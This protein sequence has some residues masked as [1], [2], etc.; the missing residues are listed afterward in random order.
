MPIETFVIQHDAALR[1]GS[2]LIALISLAAWELLVPLR[3]RKL[4]TSVRW[5]HTAGL[6]VLN[7]VLMR[8]L[9]PTA[10]VAVAAAVDH[11]RTGLLHAWPVPYALAV[12]TALLAFDFA[13]YLVHLTFHTAPLLWRIHRLHHADAD[14]DVFTALRFHPIQAA[15]STLVKLGV[16]VLL[17]APV[18]AVVIFETLFHALLLFNHANVR[19]RPDVDRVLRWF[20]V[21]P[22]MHCVHHSAR[23]QETNS[24]FGFALPWWD[25]LLGTYRAAPE[26]GLERVTLGIGSFDSVQDCRLDRMLLNPAFEQDM[27]FSVGDC[28]ETT[29]DP[30]GQA[31]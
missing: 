31:R 4:P 3:Q 10:A 26:E 30:V 22:N 1:L 9:F 2:F 6:A 29:P 12:V 11:H 16:I 7:V 15:L 8:I 5:T 27:D 24:N 25:R 13:V 14:V 18:L 17:G 19:I 28:L 21:T 23:M 20:L